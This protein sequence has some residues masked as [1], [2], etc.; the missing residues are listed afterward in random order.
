MSANI[1]VPGQVGHAPQEKLAK[2]DAAAADGVKPFLWNG[3]LFA[4]GALVLYLGIYAIAE[5]LSYSNTARNR[6]FVVRTAPERKYDYAILG[7]SHAVVFDFEDMNAR[8]E[9]MTGSKIINLAM[10]GAGVI[11]NRFILDYF[12][13]QHETNTIVYVVDSFGFYSP[14]WN[15]ERVQDTSLYQRAPF[16]PAL[17]IMLVSNPNTRSVALDYALGF[18]KINNSDRFQTDISDD[19]ANR[20][21]KTYRPVKQIDNQRLAYLYPE[22]PDSALMTKYLAEFESLLRMAQARGIRVVVVKPP[23][24][25]RWYKALPNEAQFDQALLEV[26]N[27]NNV[28]FHDYSLV[29]NDEKYFYNTDHLNRAGVLNFF[30]GYFKEIF[31][32]NRGNSE[33][34]A[35]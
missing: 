6:F 13:S 33:G 22:Q 35:K 12:L 5:Q 28:E 20:F 9:E 3:I 19:E 23:V 32:G 15:E 7:A 17:A 18:S 30:E 1:S 14:A 2:R 34:L 27:R 4:L 11:P 29:S 24:P 31:A 26:L 21:N 16:D 10:V 8:L 25:E